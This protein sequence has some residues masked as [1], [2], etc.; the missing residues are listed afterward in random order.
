MVPSEVVVRFGDPVSIN[1]SSL[2][3]DALGMGWEAQLGGIGF[4]QV[5]TVTWTV[6]ELNI[7]SIKTKCFLT[8]SSGQCTVMPNITLYSKYKSTGFCLKAK[9]I[10]LQNV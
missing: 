4:K 2:D 6:K 8:L 1:C 5:P 10:I 9:Q 7:W 3:R